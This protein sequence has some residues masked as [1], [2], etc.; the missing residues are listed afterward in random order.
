MLKKK[1]WGFTPASRILFLNS[2]YLLGRTASVLK[3]LRPSTIRSKNS[4]SKMTAGMLRKGFRWYKSMSILSSYALFSKST[5][6]QLPRIACM[7][8]RSFSHALAA[9]TT[10]KGLPNQSANKTSLYTNSDVAAELDKRMITWLQ[11]ARCA[12]LSC[13]NSSLDWPSR[14]CLNTCKKEAIL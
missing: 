1:C 7:L 9:M 4:C 6:G 3:G 12:E 8:G 11:L 2:I 13:R 14:S 5:A 10:T